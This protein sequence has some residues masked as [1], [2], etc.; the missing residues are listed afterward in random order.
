MHP[1]LWTSSARASRIASRLRVVSQDP[2]ETCEAVTQRFVEC[3]HRVLWRRALTP[4]F[5]ESA[6]DEVAAIDL[7]QD[8]CP[9]SGFSRTA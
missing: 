6:G 9:T 4:E 2:D 8:S 1:L 7:T 5:E 3:V